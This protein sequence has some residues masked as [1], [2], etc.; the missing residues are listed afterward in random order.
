M[1][2]LHYPDAERVVALEHPDFAVVALC[3]H[4]LFS[5]FDTGVQVPE[6]ISTQKKRVEF[7]STIGQSLWNNFH[8]KLDLVALY[9][10]DSA[11]VPELIR[12]ASLLQS[13]TQIAPEASAEEIIPSLPAERIG[14]IKRLASELKTLSEALPSLLQQELSLREDRE[15]AL[16][17][18][19][20][21][22]AVQEQIVAA[23]LEAQ[24]QLA[25]TQQDIAEL[26]E[27]ERGLSAAL[28]RRRAEVQSAAQRLEAL[29]ATRP[30]RAA[31]ADALRA[32]LQE[33]FD[34]YHQATRNMEWLKAQLKHLQAGDAVLAEDSQRKLQKLRAEVQEAETR[35]LAGQGRIEQHSSDSGS[36]SGGDSDA[37]VSSF[38]LSPP[39]SS[40]DVSTPARGSVVMMSQRVATPLTHRPG[41]ADDF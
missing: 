17:A 32:R 16:S 21:M 28:E 10:A 40:G 1:K 33:L 34:E 38:T 22:R 19:V 15:R 9:S 18:E 27:R 7:L 29:S 35:M 23:T 36:E 25:T 13:A 26:Q 30:A 4:W 20:D 37:D 3:L 14:E 39:G 2:S 5:R 31:E 11:A 6:D 41:Y 12:L 24:Q 8:I